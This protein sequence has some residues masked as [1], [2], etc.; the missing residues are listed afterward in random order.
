M[1]VFHIQARR[2]LIWMQAR[3]F[4]KQTKPVTCYYKLL[5]VSTQATPEEVKLS[6]YQL[7]KQI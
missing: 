3:H 6:Y 2:S 4:A 5:N 1:N 7:G